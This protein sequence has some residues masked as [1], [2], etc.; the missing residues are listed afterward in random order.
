MLAA[1][2]MYHDACFPKYFR[3]QNSDFHKDI[4]ENGLCILV[5]QWLSKR[6]IKI[7]LL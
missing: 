7:T 6:L 1:T 2:Q 3:S 4:Q 5:G